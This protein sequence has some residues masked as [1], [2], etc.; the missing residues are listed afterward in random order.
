MSSEWVEDGYPTEAALERI[1]QWPTE[2]PH[3]RLDFVASIW[4]WPDWGVSAELKPCER[5][6]VHAEEGQK[7]LRLATGGWSGNEDIIGALKSCFF[8]GWLLSAHGGLH[9]FEYRHWGSH[10]APKLALPE[11]RP[12]EAR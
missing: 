1:R 8:S 2:D 5:E 4:H 3:G 12:T 11:S 10:G 9:I 7:F 6:I